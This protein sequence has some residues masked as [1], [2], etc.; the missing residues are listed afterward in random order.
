MAKANKTRPQ[1]GFLCHLSRIGMVN[2]LVE[3]IRVIF[4]QVIFECLQH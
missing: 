4:N 1:A 3:E 2:A